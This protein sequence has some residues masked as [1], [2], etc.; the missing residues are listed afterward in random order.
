MYHYDYIDWISVTQYMLER[1][2]FGR[3][4]ASA[5]G[6]QPEGR[7]QREGGKTAE[8][9]KRKARAGGM[10]QSASTWRTALMHQ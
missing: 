9:G 7:K 4:A 6:K 8:G 2:Q 5:G 3:K 10:H 1:V